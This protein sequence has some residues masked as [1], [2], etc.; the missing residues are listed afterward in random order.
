MIL[1]QAFLNSVKLPNKQAMFK[2]NRIGMD[3]TVLYMSILVLLVSIPSLID[4]L[5]ATGG[6]SADMQLFL[7]FVYFFLFYYLPLIIMVFLLLS[8]IAYIGTGISRLMRRKIRFPILWK[9]SAYTATI[10]FILYT[11]IALIFKVDV[12]YLWLFLIYS[13]LFIIKII[14]IYPKRKIRK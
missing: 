4:R 12:M 11:I 7:L 8:L 1:L 6:A 10:P 2:L 9:M 13:I 3:I 5:T 14:T